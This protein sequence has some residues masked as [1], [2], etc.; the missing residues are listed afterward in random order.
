MQRIF[1]I[2]MVMMFVILSGCSKKKE[3]PAAE[4]QSVESVE[5]APEPTA[6]EDTTIEDEIAV[7]DTTVED[8]PQ[9]MEAIEVEPVEFVEPVPTQTSGEGYYVI[10]LAACVKRNSA[11]EIVDLLNKQG[12]EAFIEKAYVS[13]KQRDF[14]RVR[15]G[16]FSEFS[17]A[18][19]EA[20]R[21][22]RNTG[23]PYWIAPVG[24]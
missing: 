21:I 17:N 22:Q 13:S 14:Y 9:E 18:K 4:Q 1:V 7:E 19:A 23:Y 11:E 20:E 10:Q 15:V 16:A 8:I 5:A 2:G 24:L 6:M 12:V 3:E